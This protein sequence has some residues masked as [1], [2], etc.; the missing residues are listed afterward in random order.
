MAPNFT[1]PKAL[2]RSSVIKW[3]LDLDASNIQRNPGSWGDI[4]TKQCDELVRSSEIR[5][6]LVSCTSAAGRRAGK[7]SPVEI[8]DKIDR[9]VSERMN[10]R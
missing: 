4:W 7:S 2:N 10:R 6:W 5:G 1:T 9:M 3:T 8:E